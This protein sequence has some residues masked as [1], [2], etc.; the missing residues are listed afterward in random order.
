MGG[1]H[2]RS[3]QARPLV[4]S[5]V[6]QKESG[7]NVKESRS[8]TNSDP[9]PAR[10]TSA[11]NQ[12]CIVEFSVLIVLPSGENSG[13]GVYSGY[14]LTTNRFQRDFSRHAYNTH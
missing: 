5:R 13:R 4:K 8:G 9:G 7:R 11:N 1:A 2:L 14:P 6:R 3:H 12:Y 10:I